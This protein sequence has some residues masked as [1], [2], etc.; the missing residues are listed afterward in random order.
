MTTFDEAI[1]AGIALLRKHDELT[2]RFEE[3]RRQL[4][5]GEFTHYD[6]QSLAARFDGLPAS[7]DA[8]SQWRGTHLN[9][10]DRYCLEKMRDLACPGARLI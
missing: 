7:E 2:A 10:W 3:S 5:E 9:H 4:D 1:D 8:W 6:D